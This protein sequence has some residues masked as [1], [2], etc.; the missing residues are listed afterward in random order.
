LGAFES[1]GSW[2]FLS[3][4]DQIF[5]ILIVPVTIIIMARVSSDRL[6]FLH[7]YIFGVLRLNLL[8][9]FEPLPGIFNLSF[10]RIQLFFFPVLILLPLLFNQFGPIL[11]LL[12]IVL[13]VSLSRLELQRHIEHL[14][15]L[16]SV[17]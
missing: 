8:F 2:P 15:P 3:S 7:H 14:F 16:L 4:V 5:N 12:E 11:R 1:I 9:L 17:S 6:P 10:N 13:G